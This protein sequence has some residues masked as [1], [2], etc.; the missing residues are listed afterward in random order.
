MAEDKNK[1]KSIRKKID[2]GN[3]TPRPKDSLRPKEGDKGKNK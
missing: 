1:P 3:V 2:L